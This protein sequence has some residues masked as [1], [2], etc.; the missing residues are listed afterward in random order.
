[1]RR[2]ANGEQ[3]AAA[4]AAVLQRRAAAKHA[5]AFSKNAATASVWTMMMTHATR[6]LVLA[7]QQPNSPATVHA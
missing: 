3:N 4:I 6:Q 1:M 5:A 7:I 2:A